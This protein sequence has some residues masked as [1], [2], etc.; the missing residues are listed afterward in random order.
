V[1][2]SDERLDAA[3]L[4]PVIRTALDGLPPRQ[5]QVVILRDLEGLSHDEA[6]SVL[7]I[8]AGNQRLLLHRGRSRLRELLE[9]EMRRAD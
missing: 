7:G 8:S 6:C 2:E 1:E 9:A 5:R 3:A 4:L